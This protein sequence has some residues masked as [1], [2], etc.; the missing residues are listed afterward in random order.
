MAKWLGAD[1]TALD[2]SPVGLDAGRQLFERNRC[3][4]R[5]VEGDVL[6][7][8][9]DAPYDFVVHWGVLE[10]F[11]DP[12]PLLERSAR[13]LRPGGLLM[14]S[15]PNMDA[16]GAWFW[17][18]WSP[19]NWALHVYHPTPAVTG[20]LAGVG[21]ADVATFHYGLPFL[22][23]S[24]WERPGLLPSAVGAMQKVCSAAAR[25]APVFDRFGHRR[26]SMERGFRAVRR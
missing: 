21:F 23:M 7:W 22:K 18:R 2:Y 11:A 15:M 19:D 25:V 12:L 9:A 16:L 1:V 26:L 20:A 4:G 10:H 13:C 14:F 3:S 6:E 8:R 24:E 17:R 5:F